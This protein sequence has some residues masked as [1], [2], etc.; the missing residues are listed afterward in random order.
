MGCAFC[1]SL[2]W[3]YRHDR[4]PQQRVNSVL[5]PQAPVI[6]RAGDNMHLT[7]DQHAREGLGT[8][9]DHVARVQVTKAPSSA[10]QT[11]DCGVGIDGR[12]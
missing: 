1:G 8:I 2:R 12:Q 3:D 11:V 7:Q 6:E 9:L 4:T 10:E 5:M